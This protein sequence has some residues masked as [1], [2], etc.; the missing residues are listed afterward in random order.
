MS[1]AGKDCKDKG[2]AR[3]LSEGSIYESLVAPST[4]R[5]LSIIWV[6]VGSAVTEN[7]EER[8]VIAVGDFASPSCFESLFR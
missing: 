8:G 1:N 7:K 3:K 4:S 5:L 2:R 6:P